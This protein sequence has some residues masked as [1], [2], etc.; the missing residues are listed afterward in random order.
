LSLS[1]PQ[2]SETARVLLGQSFWIFCT[3]LGLDIK[4]LF[5]N[6]EN[7]CQRIPLSL[8]E[9]ASKDVVRDQYIQKVKEFLENLKEEIKK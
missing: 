6:R 8:L 5:T 7:L 4:Q 9:L 1:P 3:H 2:V